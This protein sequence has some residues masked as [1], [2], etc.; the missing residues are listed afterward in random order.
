MDIM[1]DVNNDD[2]KDPRLAYGSVNDE[3]DEGSGSYV[4]DV[5]VEDRQDDDEYDDDGNP[6]RGNGAEGRD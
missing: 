6:A 4:G 1:N 2:K 5:A 3:F